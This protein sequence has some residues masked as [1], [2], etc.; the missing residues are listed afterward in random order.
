MIHYNLQEFIARTN[1]PNAEYPLR[2]Q[3]I[4]SGQGLGIVFSI[5]KGPWLAGGAVRRLFDGSNK[6][7][8]F[9]IFF[10]SEQQLNDFKAQLLT[11]GDKVLY[12]NDL[13][14]T[15]LSN[16]AGMKP[17]KVQLIK[18][19]FENPED[20]LNWFDYTICQFLTDGFTLMVGNYTLYDVGSKRLALNTVHHGLSTVRRMLKYAN[21]G[22][23]VCDGTIV[24][25]L[26]R[27]ISNPEIINSGIISID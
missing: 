8:D 23:S 14:V 12:E 21:Q 7:S 25:I 3:E 18:F 15:M 20:V 11:L 10:K 19:Y 9:D 22:Y 4:I 17:F 26:N 6:E 2:F 27:I 24:N 16:R 1:H 5:E 13:N